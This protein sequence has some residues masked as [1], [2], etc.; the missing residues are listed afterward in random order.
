MFLAVFLANN[1]Q[2]SGDLRQLHVLLGETNTDVAGTIFPQVLALVNPL[3]IKH[4]TFLIEYHAKSE[5]AAINLNIKKMVE[6]LATSDLRVQTSMAILQEFHAVNYPRYGC[7]YVEQIKVL[8]VVQDVV[9]DRMGSFQLCCTRY[10]I[11]AVHPAGIIKPGRHHHPN[12]RST[13]DRAD[14]P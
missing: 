9:R 7:N 11:G 12:T 8:E 4:S 14:L 1:I 13:S 10:D 5:M 3:F 6:C 2:L